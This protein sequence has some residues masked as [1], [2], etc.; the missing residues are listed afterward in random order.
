MVNYLVGGLEHEF[1]FP[2]HIWDVILLIDELIFF[3]MVKTTNQKFTAHFMAQFIWLFMQKLGN[4]ELQ[5][6]ISMDRVRN[7]KDTMI[8]LLSMLHNSGTMITMLKTES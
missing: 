6:T 1:Y 3:K 7:L 4:I 2:C 5:H 8:K